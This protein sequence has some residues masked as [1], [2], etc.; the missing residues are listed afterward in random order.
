MIK[1]NKMDNLEQL[2]LMLDELAIDLVKFYGN[3]NKAASI[4]ARKMLQNIKA[5]AQV[6]RVDVSKTRN[7][8]NDDTTIN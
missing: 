2:R 3:G 8:K 7:K 6:I 4:R 1:N 5:Q